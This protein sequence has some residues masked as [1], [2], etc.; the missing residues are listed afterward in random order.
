MISN[1]CIGA[2]VI[3]EAST[4]QCKERRIKAEDFLIISESIDLLDHVGGVARRLLQ[5]LLLSLDLED[6]ALQDRGLARPVV[7]YVKSVKRLDETRGSLK[8]LKNARVFGAEV[9]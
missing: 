5:K 6:P 4:N 2:N 1:I 8:A 7:N 9:L 3:F